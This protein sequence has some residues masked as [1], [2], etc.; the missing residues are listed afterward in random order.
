MFE[1]LSFPGEATASIESFQ[2]HDAL[3][4]AVLRRHQQE[5]GQKHG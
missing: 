3:L 4:C 5:Q 1:E 2:I